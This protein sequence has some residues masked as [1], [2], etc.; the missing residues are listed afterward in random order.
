MELA[1]EL[2][3]DLRVEM[4]DRF[5]QQEYVRLGDQGPAKVSEVIEQ[6]STLIRERALRP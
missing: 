2:V 4:A 5:V 6:M 1:P 3:A